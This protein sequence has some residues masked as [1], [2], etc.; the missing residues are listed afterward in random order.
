V[1]VPFVFRARDAAPTPPPPAAEV[2]GLAMTYG[3]PP[4]SLELTVL[5]PP[6]PPAPKGRGF[7]G[8]VKGFFS[9]IFR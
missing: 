6:L 7:F 3:L 9:G 4:E 1:D 5:P 2:S 8:K